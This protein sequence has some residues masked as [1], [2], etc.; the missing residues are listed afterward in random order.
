MGGRRFRVINERA[1]DFFQMGDIL[2]IEKDDGTNTPLFKNKEGRRNYLY[3]YWTEEIDE[4][5]N[6]IRTF[7]E[8][9]TLKDGTPVRGKTAFRSVIS[10]IKCAGCGDLISYCVSDEVRVKCPSCGVTTTI[11]KKWEGKYSEGEIRI[12]GKS[13]PEMAE[14]MTNNFK[15]YYKYL[16]HGNRH[17]FYG[18]ILRLIAEE[19]SSTPVFETYTGY[20]ERIPLNLVRAVKDTFAGAG[21]VLMDG[22]G[23]EVRYNELKKRFEKVNI[24]TLQIQERIRSLLQVSKDLHTHFCFAVNGQ[25]VAGM[26]EKIGEGHYRVT[27][28]RNGGRTTD[29]AKW[30]LRA[31]K[32]YFGGKE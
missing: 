29:R 14:E 6:V 21:L 3:V 19:E 22:D 5:G 24:P 13:V 18:Q 4:K 15:G 12:Q 20:C 26:A 16:G 32:I 7:K 11:A 25:A 23:N 10:A 27:V 2:K 30:L 1:K 8:G 17:I 31:N 9:D 28:R